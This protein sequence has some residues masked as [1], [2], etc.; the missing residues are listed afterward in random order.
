MMTHRQECSILAGDS[1]GSLQATVLVPAN[2]PAVKRR[3]SHPGEVPAAVHAYPWNNSPSDACRQGN[4]RGRSVSAWG[5]WGDIL[6]SPYHCFGTACED[7]ALFRVSNQRFV[8]TSVDVAE[9]N[10]EVIVWQHSLCI[11][12]KLW[13]HQSLQGVL[14]LVCI[15][16]SYVLW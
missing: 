2:L 1:W 6:N 10:V 7:P 11:F 13:L 3:S 14:Q 4:D 15:S 16:D 12:W 8:H 5:F 9:H